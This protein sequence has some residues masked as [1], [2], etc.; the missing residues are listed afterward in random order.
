LLY[1]DEELWQ[2]ETIY[3]GNDRMKITVVAD[4]LAARDGLETLVCGSDGNVVVLWEGKLGWHREVIFADPIGQSR[5]AAGELSVL[6][7]GDKGK[8]TLA[9]RPDQR[10][11]AEFVARDTGKIRGV[12][13]A[14]VDG[15]V[16]GAELY[17][18]GYSRNVTQLVQ[19]PHGFWQAKVVFIAQR[20]LHHL[21]VG[22]IDPRHPGPEL[23]TCGHGGRL[24]ALIPGE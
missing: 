13:I 21:V 24:I 15:D 20:P 10:W 22:D 9:R 16:P 8:I 11:V 18:C 23:V 7:G 5:I 2:H 3:V 1:R 4:V 17:A 12:A 6:I 19:D 14:D